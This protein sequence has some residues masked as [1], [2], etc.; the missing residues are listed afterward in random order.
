[1]YICTHIYIYYL[2]I[3]IC[4]SIVIL[5]FVSQLLH[6]TDIIYTCMYVYIY[7]YIYITLNPVWKPVTAL[8]VRPPPAQ[9]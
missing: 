9:K 3:Y 1:M 6:L 5:S 7:I 4:L 8:R 2:F